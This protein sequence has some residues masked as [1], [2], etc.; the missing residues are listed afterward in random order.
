MRGAIIS[1][2]LLLAAPRVFPF[3]RFFVCTE[4]GD[5]IHEDSSSKTAPHGLQY[6]PRNPDHMSELHGQ[7]ISHAKSPRRFVHQSDMPHV[8]TQLARVFAKDRHSAQKNQLAR[9]FRSDRDMHGLLVDPPRNTFLRNDMGNLNDFFQELRHRR[10]HNLL[11]QSVVE[12]VH[13][14]PTFSPWRCPPKSEALA[15]QH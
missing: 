14:G 7:G 12:L 11:Q 3:H 13:E 6:R 15:C 4:S 8:R 9:I 5:T 1:S 10:M 2:M